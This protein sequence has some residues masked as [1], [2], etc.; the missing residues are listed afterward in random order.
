MGALKFDLSQA[1]SAIPESNESINITDTINTVAGCSGSASALH[2]TSGTSN[3]EGGSN[4][5]KLN[6]S[7]IG[8]NLSESLQLSLAFDEATSDWFGCTDGIWGAISKVRATAT[9]NRSLHIL[10]P[11]GFSLSKLNAIEGF[12][13]IYLAVDRWE[14]MRGLLPLKNGVFDIESNKL[15]P[16]S[17]EYKFRWQLPYVV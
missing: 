8:R 16:Y 11:Q 3:A 1:I 14:S 15:V 10:F 2:S 7:L 5:A 13:K 17:P 4:S 12:L 9:I 6:D